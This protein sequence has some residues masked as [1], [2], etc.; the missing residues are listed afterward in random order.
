MYSQDSIEVINQYYDPCGHSLTEIYINSDS[1][2]RL[3]NFLPSS[4]GHRTQQ[5]FDRS[6]GTS[7]SGH[8][9][10]PHRVAPCPHYARSHAATSVITQW[11]AT[12]VPTAHRSV[13][14]NLL[15]LPFGTVRPR[16]AR[17]RRSALPRPHSDEAALA[18]HLRLLVLGSPVMESLFI[19]ATLT[20]SSL[21]CLLSL[22]SDMTPNSRS[23]P[24]KS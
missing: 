16:T 20:G 5:S 6:Y 19:D 21:P 18:R 10:R 12:N 1:R 14:V 13:L 8:L 4:S 15:R 23:R 17:R 24:R 2:A 3:F 11:R 7:H 22:S 9:L